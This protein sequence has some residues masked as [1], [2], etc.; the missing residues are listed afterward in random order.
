MMRALQSKDPFQLLSVLLNIQLIPN[1][2][3][4]NDLNKVYEDILDLASA[5]MERN[6]SVMERGGDEHSSLFIRNRLL[7]TVYRS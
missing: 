6:K 4:E 2:L 3:P 5:D 1:M 7:Y